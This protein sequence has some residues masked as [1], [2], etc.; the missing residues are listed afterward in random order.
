MMI[1]A[2]LDTTHFKKARNTVKRLSTLFYRAFNYVLSE[3]YSHFHLNSTRLSKPIKK[4][5]I[6]KKHLVS[7]STAY[8]SMGKKLLLKAGYRK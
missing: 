8:V 6:T 2:L 1:R 7:Q 4:I 5:T 3:K